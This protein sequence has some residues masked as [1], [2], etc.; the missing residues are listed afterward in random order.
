M[1]D[2]TSAIRQFDAA[3]ANLKRLEELWTEIESLIPAGLVLDT[4]S[5]RALR[6]A[7][8]CRTFRHIR[9]AM[10]KLE[11]FELADNLQ[12]LDAIF[13]SR[14]DAKECGEI[15][16]EV[17][18]ERWIG[19]QGETLSEYRFRLAAQ[20][21]LLVRTALKQVIADVDGLL[22]I[23]A[24]RD[25]KD[26]A[27]AVEGP[28]WET[29]K[30]HFAEIDVLRGTAIPAP[31][32]WSDLR[33]HLAFGL[34]GDLRDI[35]THDWPAA[36][37]SLQEAMYG[38]DDPLPVEA[39]DLAALVTAAP[40][41][42]VTTALKWEAIDDEG[43]ERLIYNLVSDAPGYSNA[44][45]LTNTRAPDK[46]RDVSIT[47]T[48][49][50]A[51]SGNRQLRVIVQCKHWRTKAV[52]MDEVAKL[53]IQMELWEPP[54]VDEL[55]IATT[56]RFATDAVDFI[57]KRNHSRKTP[58]ITM[59]PDSHLESLLAARPHLVAQFGLR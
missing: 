53:L 38:P 11:G 20:R 14:L 1:S 33:R 54:K 13:Q 37:P 21:R 49:E 31:K 30:S 58:L 34:L 46:G 45:W 32:R 10:P 19:E 23:L 7:E 2:L 5:P 4:A 16:A 43:F 52:G 6:Y 8:L 24:K 41:G 51:L 55:I 57:E 35:I 26:P 44:Q 18:T 27:P 29:L 42:R 9:K 22:A 12:D 3:E 50:D 56:G 39:L 17:A 36:K 15:S 59:W 40:A 48:I 25:F 28:E 47:K